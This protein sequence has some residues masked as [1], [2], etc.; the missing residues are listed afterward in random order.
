MFPRGDSLQIPSQWLMELMEAVLSE[1]C[2]PPYGSNDSLAFLKETRSPY[3]YYMV[4]IDSTSAVHCVATGLKKLYEAN[5]LETVPCKAFPSIIGMFVH[6]FDFIETFN[7][8]L[9]ARDEIHQIYFDNVIDILAHDAAPLPMN[10]MLSMIKFCN[11][12]IQPQ[13]QA[14]SILVSMVYNQC[15]YG[16][17]AMDA[18]I[19]DALESHNFWR[20]VLNMQNSPRSLSRTINVKD[21]ERAIRSYL[22]RQET[23]LSSSQQQVFT[24]IQAQFDLLS[25][26]N[27]SGSVMTD[28]CQSLCR[29]VVD[30]MDVN[31]DQTKVLVCNLL[32]DHISYLIECTKK[33]PF[34]QFELLK[35]VVGSVASDSGMSNV[36]VPDDQLVYIK[37][38]I[39]YAP[40][41]LYLFVRSNDSY[42]LDECLV[43]CREH[44]VADA[45]SWLLEKTGEINAALSLLLTELS[46]HVQ[47]AK[48]GIDMHL[49]DVN[50]SLEKTIIFEILNKLGSSRIEAATRL[51]CFADLSHYLNCCIGLCSRNSSKADPTLWFTTF[52]FLLKERQS[53][54]LGSISSASEVVF[55]M[56]GQLIQSFM[57]HMRTCVSPKEII[58]TVTQ[59]HATGTRYEEF[60][61][62]MTSMIDSYSWETLVQET[63]VDIHLSD[64]F[65]LHMRKY[66]LLKKSVRYEDSFEF[67]HNESHVAIDDPKQLP[68][69][70]SY[71]RLKN[72]AKSSKLEVLSAWKWKGR[73]DLAPPNQCDSISINDD[74]ERRVKGVLPFTPKFFAEYKGFQTLG[75]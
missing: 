41:D 72:E 68:A 59:A 52:E 16:K 19:R 4:R 22:K 13:S 31:Q 15:R 10:L 63:L 73:L 62:V 17:E 26:D 12:S 43:L 38:M 33:H 54:R 28:F 46:K 42:P 60:K 64:L 27:T 66:S 74:G 35:A 5:K 61:D 11:E 71:H 24:F 34:V 45:T 1:Y 9:V 67:E 7:T 2:H 48:R 51:K 58:L 75:L 69:R 14:E 39:S 47:S 70:P 32:Q 29:K 56:I 65:N 53:I 49:R 18:Q 21:F 6:L 36:F 57:V 55:A 23:D 44:S 40:E 25:Q 30:L 3:L 20:A 50:M 8:D 37:L